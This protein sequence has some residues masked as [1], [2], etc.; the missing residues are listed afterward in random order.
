MISD[1]D[2]VVVKAFV[3]HANS[4]SPCL[5]SKKQDMVIIMRCTRLY[6]VFVYILLQV[7][8]HFIQL[9]FIYSLLPVVRYGLCRV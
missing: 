8:L 1:D 5:L 2:G 7:S 9:P 4:Q 3:V 6:P